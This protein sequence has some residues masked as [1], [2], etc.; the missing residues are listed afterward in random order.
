MTIE[1]YKN[2]QLNNGQRV[3]VHRNL[4]RGGYSVISWE[5]SSKGLV[6]AHCKEIALHNVTFIVQMSGW[7]KFWD[8]GVKNVHAFIEGNYQPSRGEESSATSKGVRV[9]YNPAL[10]PAFKYKPPRYGHHVE[11]IEKA[12][13]VLIKEY[14]IRA[15]I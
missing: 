10:S 12:E 6:V 9:T 4:N 7:K 14:D 11:Y 15:T 8:S 2:R 5:G 3:R 1:I 13:S